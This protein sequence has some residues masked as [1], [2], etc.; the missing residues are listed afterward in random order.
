MG[1][2]CKE[3]KHWEQQEWLD[4]FE[5]VCNKISVRSFSGHSRTA[6]IFV[7]AIDYDA[8]EP[9]IKFKLSNKKEGVFRVD[10]FNFELEAVIQLQTGGDFCCSKFRAKKKANES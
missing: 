8:E 3:C 4:S 10:A 6:S 2:N 5:G 1:N 7:S 9:A